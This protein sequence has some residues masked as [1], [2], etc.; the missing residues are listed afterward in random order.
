MRAAVT[1]MMYPYTRG[2]ADPN[3]VVIMTDV[4]AVPVNPN[5]NPPTPTVRWQYCGGGG[6]T[7]A[8]L[9]VTSKV[10]PGISG[11]NAIGGTTA[12]LTGVSSPFGA[13]G[14]TMANNEEILIGEVYYNY[15]PI[16]RNPVLAATQLYRASVYT[17]RLGALQWF[18]I[19]LPLRR[20]NYDPDIT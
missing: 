8:S 18:L 10:T 14:F 1:V 15:Q 9:G 12:N 11:S 20:E 5:T 2:A 7:L 4:L 3:I 19:R 17:P 13:T 16:M 6:A